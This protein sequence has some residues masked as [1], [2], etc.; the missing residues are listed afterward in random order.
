MYLLLQGAKVIKLSYS[1]LPESQF[2]V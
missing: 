1:G 2:Q